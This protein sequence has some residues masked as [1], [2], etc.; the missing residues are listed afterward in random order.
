MTMLSNNYYNKTLKEYARE[1]RNASTKAEVKLWCDLLRR[2]QMLGYQF[3]RQRAIGNYI[4]DFFCK[5]LQLI[6]EVDGITHHNEE[7]FKKDLAKET[8]LKE[9]G[10]SVLRFSDD[11]VIKNIDGVKIVIE[12]WIRANSHT[13]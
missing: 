11:D 8:V 12:E 7:T 10:Y 1:H 13:Q 2:K 4:A 5:D 3:L 9:F 6:I